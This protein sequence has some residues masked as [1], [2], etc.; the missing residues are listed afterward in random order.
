[1]FAR[2]LFCKPANLHLFHNITT[3]LPSA[4]TSSHLQTFVRWLFHWL[5][6]MICQIIDT[7]WSSDDITATQGHFLNDRNLKEWNPAQSVTLTNPQPLWPISKQYSSI[8]LCPSLRSMSSDRKWPWMNFLQQ[9]NLRTVLSGKRFDRFWCKKSNTGQNFDSEN[10]T[11]PSSF[12]S[13]CLL[14]CQKSVY[15]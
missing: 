3:A 5:H 11:F 15:F 8:S 4:A 2:R 9:S 6:Q 1:M 12:D 13:Y 10:R 7:L 14:W